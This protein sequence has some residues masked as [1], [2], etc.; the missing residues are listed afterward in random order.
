MSHLGAVQCVYLTVYNFVRLGARNGILATHTRLE[1][2]LIFPIHF[3]DR[4]IKQSLLTAH[5]QIPQPV[6][7]LLALIHAQVVGLIF[8][9]L[10]I[11]VVVDNDALVVGHD[12]G[13]VRQGHLPDR[14]EEVVAVQDCLQVVVYI[15]GGVPKMYTVV[16]LYVF[17]DREGIIAT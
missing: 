10:V 17:D 11:T 6:I 8:H 15:I 1:R 9:L 7:G 16:L 14:Q 5:L 13:V 4:I 3:P 2:P 12:D